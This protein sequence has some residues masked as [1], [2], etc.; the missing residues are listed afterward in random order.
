MSPLGYRRGRV[1]LEG[2]MWG[3][4]TWERGADVQRAVGYLG[5]D[6]R[7]RRRLDGDGR[8]REVQFAFRSFLQTVLT[9]QKKPGK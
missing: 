3:R 1:A 6:V 2:G 9:L 4:K 8:R 7:W 5:L